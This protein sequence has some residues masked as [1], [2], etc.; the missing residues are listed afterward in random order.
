MWD[1]SVGSAPVKTL[2]HHLLYDRIFNPSSTL[3]PKFEQVLMWDVRG[4]RAPT[5]QLGAY[6]PARHPLLSAVRL[7][8]ALAA[9]PGLT[10]QTPLPGT[11]LLS[12]I[13]DPL[14]QRRAAFCL[15]SGWQGEA[16]PLKFVLNPYTLHLGVL[17]SA[18][19]FLLGPLLPAIE[20][21]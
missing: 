21:R 12:L 14:D 13:L 6:G 9:V 20:Q 16:S 4:G 5:A 1:V 19:L 2:L 15:P 18:C 11:S 3:N 7:R 10:Q 17:W 8:A